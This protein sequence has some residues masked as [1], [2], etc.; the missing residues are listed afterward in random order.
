[1]TFLFYIHGIQGLHC[2]LTSKENEEERL[3]IFLPGKEYVVH[4]KSEK[5]FAT[6]FPTPHV[7]ILSDA[8]KNEYDLQ[9]VQMNNGMEET[10]KDAPYFTKV[11]MKINSLVPTP[12]QHEIVIRFIQEWGENEGYE[13][14]MTIV[15]A[16]KV[17]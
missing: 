4:L 3:A 1:M 17:N 6:C 2:F 11:T 7:R 13:V 10:D 15:M 8:N 14:E 12:S 9:I 5:D 16:Q